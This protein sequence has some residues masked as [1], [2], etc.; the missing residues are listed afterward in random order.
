MSFQ[1]TSISL[2]FWLIFTYLLSLFKRAIMQ[3]KSFIID[4][5]FYISFIKF[6]SNTLLY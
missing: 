6:N 3:I 2:D 5:I 4:K 1:A